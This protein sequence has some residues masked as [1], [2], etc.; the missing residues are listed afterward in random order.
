MGLML[1][2]ILQICLE[3]DCSTYFIVMA[4]SVPPPRGTSI[5]GGY[6]NSL[7]KRVAI[8]GPIKGP[9]IKVVVVSLYLEWAQS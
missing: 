3:E 7:G 6:L 9:L 4:L 8:K 2:W 5:S 1:L